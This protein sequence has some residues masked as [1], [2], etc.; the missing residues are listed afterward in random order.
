MD[1][2]G[3]STEVIVD[4]L[5]Y[6]D[7]EIEIE[8]MREQIDK[9]VEQE[10]RKRTKKDPSHF[11]GTFDFF[12]DSPVLASEYQRVQLGKPMEQMDTNRYKLEAPL[13]AGNIELWKKAVDNS[14]AQLEQQNLRLL[15]ME[16]LLKYGAN[17]W[18]LHNFQLEHEL[19]LFQSSL[20][21]YRQE[22]L[23]L[24]KERKAEQLQAGKKL[25]TLEYQW[26]D[27]LGKTLQVEMAC[28]S[29]ENEV[30]YLKQLEQQTR[31]EM[32]LSQLDLNDKEQDPSDSQS[33]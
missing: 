5:P 20:Q 11:P 33:Q 29:L 26:S 32:G 19:K 23:E 3:S 21:Q 28:S 24:N 13:D 22:I 4:S 31:T 15:N 10:M 2:V 27:L 8:G 30:G 18:R 14:K 7:R 1:S 17:A 9:L 6:I 25:E 12:R 16:L